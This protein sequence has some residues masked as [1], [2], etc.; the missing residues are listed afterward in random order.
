M[1]NS[2][3][4]KKC[5]SYLLQR[6]RF[7]WG[8]LFLLISCQTVSWQPPT[9]IPPV[10]WHSRFALANGNGSVSLHIQKG[11]TDQVGEAVLDWLQEWHTLKA[12]VTDP[13]GRSLLFFSWGPQTG[14]SMR[15]GFSKDL[16]ASLTVDEKGALQWNG[17]FLGFYVWELS[18]FLEGKL[19][20]E[21]QMRDVQL[22]ASQKYDMVK[23]QDRNREIVVQTLQEG[24]TRVN[25]SWSIW[26]GLRK[27]HVQI[28]F[29]AYRGHVLL[30]GD[31]AV[32]WEVLAPQS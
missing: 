12:E 16:S 30:P 1:K 24:R 22:T 23:V 17:H 29:D 2:V 9:A 26:L 20:H 6:V 19:P 27:H 21:W 25:V 5:I 11:P 14:L 8:F 3:C 28:E 7:E 4:Y 31:N 18:A 10:S 32:S 15:G 13:L